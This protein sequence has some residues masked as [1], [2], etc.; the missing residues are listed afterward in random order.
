MHSGHLLHIQKLIKLPVPLDA[1]LPEA[2]TASEHY[3]AHNNLTEMV[4]I[5]DP[6]FAARPSF[7]AAVPLSAPATPCC[8]SEFAAPAL[9]CAS[10]DRH[11][12]T[13]PDLELAHPNRFFHGGRGC[14][15]VCPP[16]V[17]PWLP[18]LRFLLF[19]IML[20][21]VVNKHGGSGEECASAPAQPGPSPCELA[22][23]VGKW[24]AFSCGHLPATPLQ[25]SMICPVDLWQLLL[26]G[27]R[28]S[29]R[30]FIPTTTLGPAR[31]GSGMYGLP[32][33]QRLHGRASRESLI[34]TGWLKSDSA[35]NL[36]ILQ[37]TPHFY[38]NNTRVAHAMLVLCT[39]SMPIPNRS[40]SDNMSEI[41]PAFSVLHLLSAV[42]FGL[43]V[44]ETW[45]PVWAGASLL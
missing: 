27:Y 33:S 14:C 34:T 11:G 19:S 42:A 18:S 1:P 21:A 35:S 16:V 2:H 38:R 26:H 13:N 45:L 8:R 23:K 28:L 36:K 25:V 4:W 24:E 40:A 41:V 3:K 43:M 12:G 17:V 7:L 31:M 22:T 10:L 20:P 15:A 6:S 30:I 9:S 44:A 29:A 39:I 32:T 37:P 5:P